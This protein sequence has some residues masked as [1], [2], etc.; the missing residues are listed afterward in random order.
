M[1]TTRI[2]LRLPLLVLATFI[3]IGAI[4]G[5]LAM[6]IEP[7]GRLLG[8]T[9]E[10]LAGTPFTDFIAPGLLLLLIVGGE[11]LRAIALLSASHRLAPPVAATAAG[12]LLVWLVAQMILIGFFW[13]QAVMLMVG[14][15]EVTM[16]LLSWRARSPAAESPAHGL[17]RRFLATG[18]V[19]FVG[20]SRDPHAFSRHL[21]DAMTSKGLDVVG[22]N[23]AEPRADDTV[24]SLADVKDLARRVVFVLVPA[25]AAL[26]VVQD[27]I[28]AGARRIWFHQ[29][30]G[31]GSATPEAITAAKWAGL[32]VVSGLC[33]YMLLEPDHWMH[34]LHRDLRLRARKV[35]AA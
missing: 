30:A 12:A 32:E 24:A 22:V 13:L 5:G 20:L 27:A 31:P 34:G 28:A 26:A 6:L 10:L 19:A 23:P 16:A 7:D 14:L 35:R 2:H 4:A 11:H 21:A 9:P 17:A 18:R 33:P 8:W 15:A 25:E 1:S 3:A 29:G